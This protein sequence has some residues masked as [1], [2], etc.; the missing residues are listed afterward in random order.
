MIYV[1]ISKLKIKIILTSK[2]D[3]GNE[4]LAQSFFI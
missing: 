4:I 3:T 1:K 2:S